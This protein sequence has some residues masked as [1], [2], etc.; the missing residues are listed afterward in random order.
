MLEDMDRISGLSSKHPEN[1]S[2][3]NAQRRA[4]REGTESPSA[5]QP[6]VLCRVENRSSNS[7]QGSAMSRRALTNARQ[8]LLATEPP[9]IQPLM[10]PADGAI[11]WSSPYSSGAEAAIDSYQHWTSTQALSPAR[12]QASEMRLQY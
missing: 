5:R 3:L 9:E 10:A 8:H 11:H 12:L 7:Q 4:S 2:V 1:A 6:A